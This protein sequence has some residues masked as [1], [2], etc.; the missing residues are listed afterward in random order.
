MDP[1]GLRQRTMTAGKESDPSNDPLLLGEIT[2]VIQ[3][4]P[5]SLNPL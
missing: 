1:A 4:R 5:S 2:V 3:E